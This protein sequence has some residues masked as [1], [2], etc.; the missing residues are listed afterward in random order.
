MH[1]DNVTGRGMARQTPGKT[2][3]LAGTIPIPIPES[4]A[5]AEK[6]MIDLCQ[7]FVHRPAAPSR[8][9]PEQPAGA[10]AGETLDAVGAAR[11]SLRKGRQGDR[12]GANA[13]R[14]KGNG[15]V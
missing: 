6:P 14:R 11:Q 7:T 13:S 12:G 2:F 9:G 15:A 1:H 4:P 5:P 10:R 8:V 3:R